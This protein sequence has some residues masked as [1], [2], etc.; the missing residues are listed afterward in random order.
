MEELWMSALEFDS[1][2]QPLVQLWKMQAVPN[3]GRS[4][5]AWQKPS[6]K[7]PSQLSNRFEERAR[8]ELSQAMSASSS[9]IT[10]Q[11]NH[12]FHQLVWAKE[13]SRK[14]QSPGFC[15]SQ[16]HCVLALCGVHSG[17]YDRNGT[18]FFSSLHQSKWQGQT[19]PPWSGVI[20]L[21]EGRGHAYFWMGQHN[22]LGSFSQGKGELRN[23]DMGLD[24]PNM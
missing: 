7:S 16:S 22:L 13:C 8:K 20:K 3:T 10:N 9:Q 4:L 15:C 19:W 2:T 14:Q 17:A 5:A 6:Q 11:I 12:S 1:T 18:L 24:F 23:E 21:P